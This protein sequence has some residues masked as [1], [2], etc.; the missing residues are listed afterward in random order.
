MGLVTTDDFAHLMKAKRK[1]PIGT[2]KDLEFKTFDEAWDFL[3]APYKA[4]YDTN[5]ATS[6]DT[7]LSESGFADMCA[8]LK[9]F[10]E[11]N[12]AYAV[13]FSNGLIPMQRELV[14]ITEEICKLYVEPY[15]KSHEELTKLWER[16]IAN[17]EVFQ[18]FVEDTIQTELFRA[19]NGNSVLDNISKEE[20]EK[21]FT[22]DFYAEIAKGVA[23]V[24][25]DNK[26]TFL[27]SQAMRAIRD[28]IT[29]QYWPPKIKFKDNGQFQT[30]FGDLAFPL[31]KEKLTEIITNRL[32]YTLETIESGQDKT[33]A[34]MF[35][36]VAD[37]I[38]LIFE[39]KWNNLFKDDKGFEMNAYLT[40]P[41]DLKGY[42]VEKT[43]EASGTD[44]TS[45]LSIGAT[46]LGGVVVQI[47]AVVT[48]I[49]AM[50]AGYI[51]FI[52]CDP[53]F[54][55]LIVCVL[56]GIGGA[57]V[58]TIAGGYV[59][60][61]FV[62]FLTEKIEPKIKADASASFRHMIDEQMKAILV[63]YSDGRVVDIQ[64]MRNQRDIAL[65]PNPH[66]EENCFRAIEI[67]QKV[68][69]QLICYGN[70]SK[71]NLK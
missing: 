56:L 31:I 32:K 67:L 62:E 11:K 20:Y 71:T 27:A 57:I 29:I 53:T 68:N 54:T 46:L 66:Q 45:D 30:V 61:K 48:G 13:I 47:S 37:K 49:A 39:Q 41:R 6:I 34:N 18:Q 64:K 10:I 36:P 24:I 50:I 60:E 51:A 44:L 7:Y 4:A 33:I 3:I 52:L 40:V 17:A 59:R 23:E 65:T 38:K 12:E 15:T 25:Y 28:D 16:R 35:S 70:Y 8:G 9:A 14:T 69:D 19:N 2:T 5:D 63:R 55:V 42:V 21:I 26:R 58:S 1:T 43:T 22:N